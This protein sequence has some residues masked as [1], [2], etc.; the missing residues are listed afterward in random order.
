MA[1]VCRQASDPVIPASE[2]TATTPPPCPVQG[3]ARHQASA[4]GPSVDR[5]SGSST[6]AAPDSLGV[7]RALNPRVVLHQVSDPVVPTSTATP[8]IRRQASDPVSI[9]RQPSAAV[10]TVPRR[11]GQGQAEQTRV[12]ITV[13]VETHAPPRAA[14]RV[15]KEELRTSSL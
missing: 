7:G 4:S 6:A 5:R 14:A 11:Q 2:V 9:L 3:P 13:P 1:P 12:T 8:P 10:G 15:C